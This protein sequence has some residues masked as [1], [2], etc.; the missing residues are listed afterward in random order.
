MLKRSLSQACVKDESV[1]LVDMV[2][3]YGYML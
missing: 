3:L 2:F 1:I